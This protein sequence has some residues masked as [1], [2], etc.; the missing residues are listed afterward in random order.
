MYILPK[1]SEK[2]FS[3]LLSFDSALNNYIDTS[4][5]DWFIERG[6]YIAHQLAALKMQFNEGSGSFHHQSFQ[7][8]RIFYR[9]NCA[10]FWEK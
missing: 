7:S 3:K 10:V 5:Q 9:I 1:L 4:G 8:D 2:T 6:V